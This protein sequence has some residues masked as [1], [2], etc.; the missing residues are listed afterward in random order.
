VSS[1]FD[2]PDNGFAIVYGVDHAATRKATYS[3]VSVY[4]DETLDIGVASADSAD[5]AESP[6]TANP[7][8]PGERAADKFYV[9][10]V[11]R[12][13]TGY[14]NCLEA[15]SLESACEKKVAADAPVRIAFRAYA[16][17]ATRVGP[18]DAELIYDRVIVFTPR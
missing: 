11:R 6:H 16:E 7:Y 14:S 17:P 1:W 5:F 4:L 13:C 8:L 9:W 12:D 2:L 10:Q 3:S 18:A 15:K